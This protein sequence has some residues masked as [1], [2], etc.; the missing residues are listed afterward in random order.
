MLCEKNHT[1]FFVGNKDLQKLEQKEVVPKVQAHK[2]KE[3]RKMARNRRN[4]RR[5]KSIKDVLTTKTFIIIIS[6]LLVIII[7]SAGVNRYR[8]YQDQKLL[9]SQKEEIEKQSQEIFSQMSSSISQT[10]QAISESDVLIKMSAV[11]DILCSRDMLEDA[12]DED[13]KTYD[14]SHMFNNVSGYINNADIVM[15]TMETSI[16]NGEYND[17]NAP[18]EFARAVKDSGVNLVTTAHNHSLDNGVTGLQETRD[19]LEE[20]GFDVIGDKM[21]TA[22]AVVI[23][24]AKNTK[25]AFLTYTC[26]LDNEKQKSKDEINC[27]NM[28][29]KEQV[30]SDLEYAQEQGAEYICA[31]IH[32]GDAITD[33][34]TEEQKEIADYL[35]ESG[36]DLIIGAH[37]SVVQPMEV[38]QNKDGENVFIA[39]SIGTYISTLTAEEARTEL[40]LNIELR[41]SGKDG[42]VTLN[43][44]DYTPIYMLDNGEQAEDRFK[45]IDMKGTATSYASGNTDIVTRETYDK[46]VKALKKLNDILK[47]E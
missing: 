16:A 47:I 29:S 9:A 7:A 42:K 14:F 12:Y 20:I 17:K 43:K 25:I 37:P 45:L 40:V 27:V 4:T 34:V 44:V 26:F 18:V 32:W 28:Y 2:R 35:V 10:N 30:K 24:E 36:V 19:N 21:E 39:Y 41:K 46:L 8:A 3:R 33:T 23:R 11:G 38:R 5:I 15:G 1:T 31:M 22:N 6:I 13:T